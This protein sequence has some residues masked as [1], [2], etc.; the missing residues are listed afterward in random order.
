MKAILVILIIGLIAIVGIALYTYAN[1]YL[2]NYYSQQSV[3]YY[4]RQ[5]SMMGYGPPGPTGMM[6]G[7]MGGYHMMMGYY[8]GYAYGYLGSTS[9]PQAVQAIRSVQPYARVFPQNDTIVFYS[10]QINLVVL[11]MGHQRALNL[12]N[13]TPPISAHAQ[14][15]VFV[16]DGLINPTLI[17]P[18]ESVLNIELINLDAGD[19]HNLAITPVP[20][21]Y[22]YY[23]MMYIRMDVMG[24]TPMIPPANY[25]GGE[26]YESSFTMYLQPGTYYYV[27]EYPGHAEMGMYGEIMVT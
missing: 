23:S 1:V 25:N 4:N 15:N 16:I 17:V 21:P 3:A 20:P 22:P 5:L 11:S 10:T 8:E 18:G 14:N 6:G 9:I 19:F 7:M 26:A 12:T 24:M 13:Y 2:P 27:C